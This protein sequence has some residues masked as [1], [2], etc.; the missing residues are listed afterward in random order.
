MQISE[1]R[2]E[3]STALRAFAWDQWAQMGVLARTERRD[4]WAQDPEA[5]LVF[6]LE[7]ARDEPRLFHEV[8]DWLLVNERIVS[9]Q[10]LRNLSLDEADRALVEASLGWVARR[11]PRAR[12]SQKP[13]RSS[14]RARAAQPLFRGVDTA[15]ERPDDAFLERGLLTPEVQPTRKSQAPD[16]D[17][18]INFAFR[19]RHLLGVGAR[20]EVVRVLLCS[21]APRLSAQAIAASAGYAKRNVQEALTSLRTGRVIDAVT[22]AN[23]QRY[24][25]PRERWAQL[26]GLTTDELPAHREWPQLLHA[27]RRLVRWLAEP[28]REELSDY[29]KASDARVLMDEIAPELRLAGGPANDSHARGTEYWRDFVETVRAAVGALS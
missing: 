28:S 10:R 19:M 1:L 16:P 13:A 4:R 29:M 7:V 24:G 3:V 5:L 27:L 12:L 18:P 6:T 11:R 21:D 14:A 2:N 26:L 20:A 22:V 25:V 9:V 17:V 23:K 8:L 15:I